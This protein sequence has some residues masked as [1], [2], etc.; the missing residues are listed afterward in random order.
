MKREMYYTKRYN[1]KD[2]LLHAI[3]EYMDYYTY[4]RVQRKLGVLTPME[5]HEKLMLAA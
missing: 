5:Y 3:Y 4:R 2:E 1:T